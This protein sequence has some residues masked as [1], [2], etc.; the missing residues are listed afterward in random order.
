MSPSCRSYCARPD[1]KVF[2]AAYPFKKEKEATVT[3]KLLLAAIA[4]GLWANAAIWLVRPVQAQSDQLAGG[5]QQIAEELRQ[6]V[7]AGDK[8]LNPQLCPRFKPRHQR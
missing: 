4:F 3:N 8:C 7:E 6:L 5:V 2:E 1:T